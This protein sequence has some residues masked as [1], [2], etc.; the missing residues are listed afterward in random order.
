MQ[1]YQRCKDVYK[2]QIGTR[3]LTV[4]EFSS[5]CIRIEAILNSRPVTALSSDPSD[6]QALTPGHFLVGRPISAPPEAEVS[7]NE[8]TVRHY[9]QIAALLQAFWKRWHLE[10]LTALHA[11][12]KWSSKS[13][14]L[15][16]GDL[17]VLEEQNSPPLMWPLGQ[18]S[19]VFL[20][21]DGVVRRV[22]VKTSAGSF[23]R[24]AIKLYRLPIAS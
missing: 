24:P 9:K 10:Y 6:Y 23:E 11:R 1:V 22:L 12:S 2:R 21:S 20:G 3:S 13:R 18:V 19:A 7:L 4:A 17:V 8:W 15:M 5:L 16:V 14:N